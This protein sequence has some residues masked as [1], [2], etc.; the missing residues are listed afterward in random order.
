MNSERSERTSI[1]AR[2]LVIRNRKEAFMERRTFFTLIELLVV[3]AIIAILAAMLLPALSQARERV[4]STSCMS[5]LKQN[6]YY[7]TLYSQD[8]K[9]RLPAAAINGA[10]GKSAFPG[11]SNDP[12]R[13]WAVELAVNRYIPFFPGNNSSRSLVYCPKSEVTTAENTYGM[14]LGARS[15]GCDARAR[16]SD[17]TA[18]YRLLTRCSPRE[19]MLGDSSRGDSLKLKGQFW[20]NENAV[21]IDKTGVNWYGLALRHSDRANVALMDGHVEALSVAKI[22]S[23]TRADG[24]SEYQLAYVLFE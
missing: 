3:I 11:S 18:Y 24:N 7:C 8:F 13:S 6:S 23:A 10:W 16:S 12:K 1:M 14:P 19:V 2:H 22:K 20:I 15:L 9:D 5:N 21:P 4:R 17:P